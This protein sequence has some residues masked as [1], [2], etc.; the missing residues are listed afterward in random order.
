MFNAYATL[1]IG[2]RV[3]V[4]RHRCAYS[5][6]TIVYFCQLN[7]QATTT[8][9]GVYVTRHR[10]AYAKKTIV[11]FCQLNGQATTTV[12][13]VYVTLQR[14]AYAKKIVLYFCQLPARATRARSKSLCYAAAVRICWIVKPNPS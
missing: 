6:K 14:C 9:L 3:Y 8:V 11:Y 7:G 10:C 12:L 5:K 13:G 1:A 4:T 2:L